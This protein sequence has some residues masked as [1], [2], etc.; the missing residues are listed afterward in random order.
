MN[1]NLALLLLI[2]AAGIMPAEA[3]DAKSRRQKQLGRMLP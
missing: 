1:K 3:Q 2:S